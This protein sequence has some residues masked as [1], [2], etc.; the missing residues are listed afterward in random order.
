MLRW[1]QTLIQTALNFVAEC[2]GADKMES[3]SCWKCWVNFSEDSK[4]NG[5][6]PRTTHYLA[7]QLH[8]FPP[9]SPQLF[10]QSFLSL[11]PA[12]SWAPLTNVIL[13]ADI[14]VSSENT[15]GW[16]TISLSLHHTQKMNVTV[17]PGC[18]FVAYH[19]SR[20]TYKS[21]QLWLLFSHDTLPS[22]EFHGR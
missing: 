12:T 19:T 6:F 16:F 5:D 9:F 4:W 3:K 22:E 1:W 21:K 13:R 11:S 18:R 7:T 15:H 10:H 2:E 8:L 20:S 17:S 14:L